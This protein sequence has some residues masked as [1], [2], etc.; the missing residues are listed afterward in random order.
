MKK[1]LRVILITSLV[2]LIAMGALLWKMND[3]A[4][5]QEKK[6]QTILKEERDLT[7]EDGSKVTDDIKAVDISPLTLS[8][9][10]QNVITT[11][12]S[13]GN[14]VYHVEKSAEVEK[15][16]TD[17]KKN[18]HFTF[19][20]PMWAYNP[21]GTNKLSLYLYFKSDGKGYCRYTISVDDPSVP[22]FTRTLLNDGNGN[23]SKEHEYQ[24]IGLIPGQRNI[25]TLRLYNRKDELSAVQS[26]G[27]DVP[28][29][30]DG[31][32][33]RLG[34]ETGYSK[35]VVSN[36]LYTSFTG[37]HTAA[38]GSRQYAILQ[39]DNSGYLR[40][41]IPLNGDVSR[42]MQ[43]IYDT[44]VYTVSDSQ[45]VKVNDLGQVTGSYPV[46]GY[47][48]SGPYAYDGSGSL[49]LIAT[50]RRKK[51]TN[52]SKIL[53]LELETGEVT[54]ALDLD[55]LL[56]QVHKRNKGRNWIDI[57]SIQVVGT[58]QLLLSSASLSSIFK[59]SKVGSLLPEVNYI[60]GDPNLWKD[61]KGLKRKVLAK[62]TGESDG[63]NGEE[64]SKKKDFACQYGQN[65]MVYQ[66]GSEGRYT[67]ELLNNNAGRGA[68]GNAQSYYYQYQVDETAGTYRLKSSETLAQTRTAGN[69]TVGPEVIIYCNSDA[70]LVQETDRS[71]KL[72]RQFTYPFPV[73]RTYKSDWKGFWFY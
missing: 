21:Y 15:M 42:N 64:D 47:Q 35:T 48:I 34:T 43:V 27:L 10:E 39:Y 31:A 56:P 59:V 23:L 36:G 19:A 41:D 73:Y 16:L 55:T 33:A 25:I 38:D 68:G 6:E 37:A 13:S 63:G 61:Y 69:V 20:N 50:A 24:V 22:D 57:N 66:S 54:E 11:A 29:L 51:A 8:G 3:L 32:A 60:I 4:K 26:Y 58:N 28:A 12:L 49:Y 5:K 45:V 2:M 14:D 46:N 30:T 44:L 18:K 53:K 7:A 62:D 71:G 67:L 40:S 9:G 70:K 17:I 1:K 52:N 72:I 65:S